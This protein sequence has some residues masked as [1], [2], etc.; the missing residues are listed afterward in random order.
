[1][2]ITFRRAAAGD[3][4]DVWQIIVEAKQ[5]MA[6]QGRR[7]W[8]EGYPAPATIKGDIASGDAR[9]ACLPGGAVAAYA[10]IT[11]QPEPAYGEIDGRWL[12]AGPYLTVHRLAVAIGARGRGLGRMMMLE[13]E[14]M[15]RGAGAASV[16]VD[17]NHDN[18]E[19]L[20]LLPALGYVRC[21]TVSYGPRGE[22]IAFEK[23]V[24]AG[25]NGQPLPDSSPTIYQTT[26]MK[27]EFEKMRSCELYRF[28]DKE[29]LAS[30]AHAKDLCRRLQTMTINDGGYRAVVE[31]LI[32][33]L[34]ASSTVCPPFHCDHGNGITIGENVFVNYDAVMLDGGS[35]RI[36]NNVQIGPKCQLYTPQHPIDHVARREPQET[37]YPIT[38]GDDTWLGGGVVVCPGVTIGARCIIA[39][40]SVVV[41]DIPDDCLA[42]GNPAVVKKR[43]DNA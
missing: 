3:F 7:Q 13:A 23:A 4:G 31:E 2:D 9:V 40:G 17:T 32:P 28:D 25:V 43:L 26:H 36:G 14:R 19:M 30:L 24:G 33:G 11:P 18:A 38:I 5:V 39:A 10:C 41:R 1:M 37:A 20:R 27:T 34:P 15:A 42:A 35:I 22:R 12:A 6:A 16:R 29:I 21:G 8:T